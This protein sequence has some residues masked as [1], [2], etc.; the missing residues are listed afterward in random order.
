MVSQNEFEMYLADLVRLR[1]PKEIDTFRK[2]GPP[3][4]EQLYLAKKQRA[5]F[6]GLSTSLAIERESQSELTGGAVPS[7][8]EVLYFITIGKMAYDVIHKILSDR[9]SSQEQRAKL[10]LGFK[11]QLVTTYTKVGMTPEEARSNADEDVQ[12]LL[13]LNG[14]ASAQ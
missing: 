1:L 4:V 8:D 6:P 3:L 12:K 13:G 9:R 2:S 10:A 5:W 11:R 7:G 14:I